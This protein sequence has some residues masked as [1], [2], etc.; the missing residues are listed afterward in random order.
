MLEPSYAL[1]RGAGVVAQRSRFTERI[2][3]A[4]RKE[5]LAA[6]LGTLDH[7]AEKAR[8]DKPAALRRGLAMRQR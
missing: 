3:G 6:K 7:R 4:R 5:L 8:A 2:F 1:A